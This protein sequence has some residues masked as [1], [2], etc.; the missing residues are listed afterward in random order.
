L[1]NTRIGSATF[2]HAL[3]YYEFGFQESENVRILIARISVLD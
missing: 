3:A 2:S 1:W